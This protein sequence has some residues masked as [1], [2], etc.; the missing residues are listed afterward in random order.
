MKISRLE[1]RYLSL[2]MYISVC[3]LGGG[4]VFVFVLAAIYGSWCK[5]WG[6]NSELVVVRRLF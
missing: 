4:E 1:A 5:S 3:V 6:V 2:S